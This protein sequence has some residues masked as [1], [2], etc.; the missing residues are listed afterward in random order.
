MKLCLNRTCSGVLALVHFR[1]SRFQNFLQGMDAPIPP[2]PLEKSPLRYTF[3]SPPPPS[4]VKCVPRTLW[5]KRVPVV[6]LLFLC[7]FLC[8]VYFFAISILDISQLNSLLTYVFVWSWVPIRFSLLFFSR[9]P[10]RLVCEPASWGWVPYGK[11]VRMRRL[12][13]V[14]RLPRRLMRLARTLFW[15]LSRFFL[16]ALRA[17]VFWSKIRLGKIT[18]FF[19][20]LLRFWRNMTQFRD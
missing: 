19:M 20:I 5:L 10:P 15:W 4:N 2:H 11:P 18:T 1:A 13:L 7:V 3:S 12:L 9:L 14:L 6:F 17:R 16:I 8:F